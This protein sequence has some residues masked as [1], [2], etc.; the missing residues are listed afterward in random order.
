MKVEAYKIIIVNKINNSP[1]F[2][3]YIFRK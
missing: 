3:T 2:H 1:H